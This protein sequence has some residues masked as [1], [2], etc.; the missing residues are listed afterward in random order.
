LQVDHEKTAHV[1]PADTFAEMRMLCSGHSIQLHMDAGRSAGV[2]PQRAGLV[3][4]NAVYP[5]SQ[6]SHR[7][8]L[9]L[10]RYPF[11][12]VNITS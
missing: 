4:T 2:H 10:S 5:T 9:N 8:I 12:A 11:T 7:C 1:V 3:D 6:P